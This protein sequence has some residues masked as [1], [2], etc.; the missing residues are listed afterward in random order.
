[1]H[2]SNFFFVVRPAISNGHYRTY[3]SRSVVFF[4][5]WF[6]FLFVST[7][8]YLVF[9]CVS[10]CVRDQRTAHAYLLKVIASGARSHIFYM[11]RTMMMGVWSVVI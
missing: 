3:G 11:L 9:F 5:F 7:I 8:V 1:M 2:F 6:V 10:V 4:W